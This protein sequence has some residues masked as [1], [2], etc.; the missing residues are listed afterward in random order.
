MLFEGRALTQPLEP[1]LEV[2][3]RRPL[4]RKSVPAID[5]GSQRDLG[6]AE[7][8]TGEIR[9]AFERVIRNRPGG[10]RLAARRLYRGMITLLRPCAD[11]T[12]QQRPHWRADAGE[13]PIHP[14]LDM[15]S[16]HGVFRVEPLA[17][18]RR[19]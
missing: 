11:E 1:S 9:T 14:S 8:R 16:R 6:E 17:V 13:L 15:C 10:Q 4:D 7:L 12:E 2:L 19:A 3:Q 5:Q 18:A